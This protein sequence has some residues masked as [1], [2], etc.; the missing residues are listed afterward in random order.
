[1]SLT[2]YN[3]SNLLFFLKPSQNKDFGSR[4]PANILKQLTIFYARRVMN[5][6]P[7]LLD[8]AHKTLFTKPS[9]LNC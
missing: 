5:L 8:V 7:K 1:M 2:I 6:S 9:S 3:F 4:S